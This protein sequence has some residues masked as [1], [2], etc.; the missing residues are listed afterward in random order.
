M[1]TTMRGVWVSVIRPRRSIVVRAT[2]SETASQSSLSAGVFAGR[3]AKPVR[4]R[5]SGGVSLG[6]GAQTP[7]KR[8]ASHKTRQ[9]TFPALPLAAFMTRRREQEGIAASA[10]EFTILTA[11]R[12]GEIIG[13]TSRLWA[14]G[15]EIRPGC[16][17]VVAF[18][19]SKLLADALT[20][21]LGDD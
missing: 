11:A 4:T 20:K 15:H 21:R 5:P 10:L 14:V 13:A 19:E 8:C 12:T 7:R 16:L 1:D 2:R 18:A 6:G 3:L 9:W 17:K